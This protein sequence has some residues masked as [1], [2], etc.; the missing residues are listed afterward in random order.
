MN[1]DGRDVS[2]WDGGTTGNCRFDLARLNDPSRLTVAS[3][4]TYGGAVVK[5]DSF[6]GL[7]RAARAF[8]HM[9]DVLLRRM[10]DCMS[11]ALGP[12]IMKNVLM[13]RPDL[14]GVSTLDFRIGRSARARL[15]RSGRT[16]MKEA[17][18]HYGAT[19]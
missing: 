9:L 4:V 15:A 19:Q 18:E 16:A 2:C 10:E 13:V 11:E 1:I 17:L 14:G 6:F 7:V 8:N 12:E 5:L 3:S